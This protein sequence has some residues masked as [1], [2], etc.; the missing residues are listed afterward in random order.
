MTAPAI[1]RLRFTNL[2]AES[3][4]PS[5][6]AA[7]FVRFAFL[8]FALACL[9]LPATGVR[10]QDPGPDQ[11]IRATADKIIEIIKGDK[12][13]QSG[14]MKRILEVAE[15]HAS[16]HFNFVRTTRLAM[17][18]NWKQA[19]PAQQ[20]ALVREFRSL[21]LRTY[22][23]ALKEYRNQT[24]EV[25]PLKL[26]AGSTDVQVKT[27]VNQPGAKAIPIDYDMERTPQ[28]WKVYDVTVGG[29]SLVVNFRSSFDSEIRKSG[30]DGLV[31]S[32]VERNRSASA[33]IAPK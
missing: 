25:R 29:V 21:L 18:A 1:V 15:T 3:M 10:A 4:N 26:P 31:S 23:V 27:L 28:G 11:L 20:D 32:L 14:D 6:P 24:I 7:T 33:G 5:I 2:P 16:P 17:G 19:S 12:A 9:S 30:I 13:I 8:L 22:A